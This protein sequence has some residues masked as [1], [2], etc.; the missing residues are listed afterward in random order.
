MFSSDR[1]AP[2]RRALLALLV[3]LAATL[4]CLAGSASA[5]PTIPAT[6]WTIAGNGS[7]CFSADLCGDGG[8]AT[9][10]TLGNARGVAVDSAGN[11]YVSDGYNQTLRKITPAGV[12]TRI[13]GTG[14]G[15]STSTDP[16]GDGGPATSAQFSIPAG[17]AVD[18][19]RNV[20]LTA[21]NNNKIRKVTPAGTISTVAG[22]G[23]AC[24]SPDAACGD[25]GQA[26]S[27]QLNSPGGV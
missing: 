5:Y 11:V 17:L 24:S 26:T 9:A 21:Q 12:I 13:A 20:Y 14:A 16:C 1:V 15:C 4:A 2:T 19:A 27:A 3:A 10:A 7:G 25:G 18:G 22:S 8:Q 6:I 23:D